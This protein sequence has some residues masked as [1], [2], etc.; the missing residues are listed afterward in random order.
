MAGGEKLVAQTDCYQIPFKQLDRFEA[1][2]IMSHLVNYFILYLSPYQEV[3]DQMS[4]RR[5][6]PKAV[7]LWVKSFTIAT[8]P[9]FI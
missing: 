4:G 3:L 5:W 7:I 6:G 1:F 9:I 8:E 2:K